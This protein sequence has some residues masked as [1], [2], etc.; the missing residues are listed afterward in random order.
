MTTVNQW[1][2]ALTLFAALG[3]GLIA[4]VFSAFSTFMVPYPLTSCDAAEASR[5]RGDSCLRDW[6]HQLA[7]LWVGGQHLGWDV[8]RSSCQPA[9]DV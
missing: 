7:D 5:H 6:Q 4:G 3:C 8:H 1:L 9:S 2:F